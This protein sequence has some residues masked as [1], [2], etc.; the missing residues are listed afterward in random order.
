MTATA[1]TLAAGQE[2][3][4]SPPGVPISS[5]FTAHCP[6]TMGPPPRVP[7]RAC[8]FLNVMSQKSI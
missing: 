4:P 8:Y 2:D 5:L 6:L 7:R 1:R 3:R